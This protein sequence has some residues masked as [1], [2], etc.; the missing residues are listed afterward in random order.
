MSKQLTR[1]RLLA[2]V[3]GIAGLALGGTAGASPGLADRS[4]A[5]EL[6]LRWNRTYAPNR[7]NQTVSLLERDDQYVVLGA[8]GGQPTQLS[9]WLFGVDATTG[10]GQWQTPLENPDLDGQPSFRQFDETPD[11]DGLVVT[12]TRSS[13]GSVSL[14][15]AGPKGEVDWW[16]T[17]GAGAESGSV[18]LPSLAV[19]EDGYLVG[20]NRL[21][22]QAIDAVVVEVAPDGSER[23]R[24]ALFEDEQSTL[25]D[26]IPDGEGGLVG[27]GQLQERTT[28]TA[29]QPTARGVVFRLNGDLSVQWRREFTAP[30][31]G[32]PFQTN[33]LNAVTRTADGYAV[34]GAALPQDASSVSGWILRLDESGSERASQLVEP[35]PV[36]SLTN[37]VETS[38]GL[39]V[40]GQVAESLTAQSASGLVA[41]LGSD[42]G[43]RWSKILGPAA[44]N[45]L[46]DVVA[47]SDDGIAVVGIAQATS[48][49]ANPVTQSWLVK[50]GG[51]PAPSVT[52][53][54][55][56]RNGSTATPS[57]T[58]TPTPEP[59]PTPSPTPTVT[60]T[61]TPT[62]VATDT[63]TD[64]GTTTGN[65]P[66]FGALGTL[67]ALGSSALYRRVADGN[68]G[69][70][71]TE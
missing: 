30:T 21:V 8:T 55:T 59:T 64:T 34:V 46:R 35:Q 65:G 6:P 13:S 33:R 17:F 28:S 69:D 63:P 70:D 62:D 52:T 14:V 38:D 26:A 16:E 47:T 58:P 19:V 40:T 2:S 10:E 36:T 57:P 3:G 49:D 20:A 48:Q 54:T 5:D 23:S 68:D 32:D 31:D 7:Y 61:A 22:D 29:D 15:R 50:L 66:G 12:G 71:E 9:G 4:T 51:E 27:V 24:T 1:R 39:T 67:T 53:T 60:P 41:E 42:G 11:G 37:V 45:N 25:L 43:N 56:S 18:L 44:T